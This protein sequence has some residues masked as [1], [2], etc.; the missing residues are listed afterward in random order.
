MQ[1]NLQSNNS[2]E[3]HTHTQTPPLARGLY[4]PRKCSVPTHMEKKAAVVGLV[5]MNCSDGFSSINCVYVFIIRTVHTCIGTPHTHTP[6]KQE[7][8]IERQPNALTTLIADSRRNESPASPNKAGPIPSG[9]LGG[10]S[11]LQH[12][13]WLFGC[14]LGFKHSPS[15]CQR[16]F[17]GGL[18][19]F[20]TGPRVPI[21]TR[22]V[23]F[24][25]FRA[26][27]EYGNILG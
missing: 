25:G 8:H 10:H 7:K 1:L 22:L 12:T 17:L 24:I 14:C 3:K 9:S 27:R 13:V 21:G 5:V 11:N 15:L 18:R 23:A 20:K 6:I 16:T 19:S 4:E 26:S 2:V